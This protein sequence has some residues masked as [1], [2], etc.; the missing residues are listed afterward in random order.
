ML[1]QLQQD[2]TRQER[3]TTWVPDI[4]ILG[5]QRPSVLSHFSSREEAIQ[6][7]LPESNDIEFHET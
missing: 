6:G 4:R 3:A 2:D 7:L 1:S 5:E